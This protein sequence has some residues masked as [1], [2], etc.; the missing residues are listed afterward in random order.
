MNQKIAN[1]PRYGA[2]KVVN[3]MMAHNRVIIVDEGETI[4]K[5]RRTLCCPGSQPLAR[6]VHLPPSA[7]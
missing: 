5:C 3:I 2:L 1:R 6:F 7:A 4:C